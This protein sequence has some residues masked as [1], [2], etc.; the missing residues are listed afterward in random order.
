[1]KKLYIVV[2]SLFILLILYLFISYYFPLII[3]S[4][5]SASLDTKLNEDI[6]KKNSLNAH[7]DKVFIEPGRCSMSRAVQRKLLINNYLE[8]EVLELLGP[9]D[10]KIIGFKKGYYLGFCRTGF[11]AEFLEINYDSN[12]MFKDL[13]IMVFDYSYVFISDD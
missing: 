7:R 9:Y 13:K 6:W 2:T 12:N 5:Q 10:K 4:I 1:M 8:S 11:E 3:S